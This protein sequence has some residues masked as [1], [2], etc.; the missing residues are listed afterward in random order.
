MPFVP[1]KARGYGSR[2]SPGR[3]VEGSC[4]S[5]RE[6]VCGA[7]PHPP[8]RGVLDRPGKLDGDG[9]IGRA[10]TPQRVVPAYAGTH[11]PCRLVSALG[12]MPF[13]TAKARGYGSRRSPGRLVEGSCTSGREIVCGAHPHPPCRDVLDRPVKPDDDGLI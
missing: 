10:T 8:C 2:R 4:T 13:V 7:H 5:R 6:I 11:T 3:L 9:G 12:Q 1:R